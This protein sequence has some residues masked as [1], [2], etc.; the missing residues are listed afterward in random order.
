MFAISLFIAIVIGYT[1]KGKM[2]NLIHLEFKYIGLIFIGFVLE[3]GI[4]LLL[5]NQVWELGTLTYILDLVMYLFIFAFVFFNR[6]SKEIIL[7]AIGFFLNAIVIFANGGAMPVSVKALEWIGKQ[8]GLTDKGL[9][10]IMSEETWFKVLGDIIPIRLNQ[11]AFIISLGDIILCI[12]MM[13]LIIKGMK[14]EK[15]QET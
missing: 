9:Y 7:M 6:A 3:R 14:I 1:L 11:I 8:G 12:G 2:S 10:Q 15:E 4:N 5:Q 13:I